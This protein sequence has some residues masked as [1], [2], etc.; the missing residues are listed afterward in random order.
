[1]GLNLAKLKETED[2]TVDLDKDSET[3][4][5]IDA[6]DESLEKTS[7]TTDDFAALAADITPSEPPV[8]DTEIEA[9]TSDS[10]EIDKPV[11]E[12][13]LAEDVVPISSETP[14]ADESLP[15]E[16][17]Q[18]IKQ[19]VS[20]G[21]GKLNLAQLS[22]IEDEVVSLPSDKNDVED[23]SEASLTAVSP[24]RKPP[25]DE[26]AAL[27]VD[28]TPSEPPTIDNDAVSA[29]TSTS[30][31]ETSPVESITDSTK[32]SDN[33]SD[34]LRALSN[35][36]SQRQT[37]GTSDNI[38]DFSDVLASMDPEAVQELEGRAKSLKRD[39]LARRNGVDPSEMREAM[40]EQ[41]QS[42]Q[43]GRQPQHG[44]G[45]AGLIDL[46]AGLV[47]AP[48][49]GAALGVSKFRRIISGS[50]NA[51]TAPDYSVD[52]L[53]DRIYE[54]KSQQMQSNAVAMLDATKTLGDHINAFNQEFQASDHMRA[55]LDEVNKTPGKSTADVLN[56][57]TNGTATPE[58]I[59]A[60][61]KVLSDPQVAAAWKNVE[62]QVDDLQKCQNLVKRDF[63][64]LNKN[65]PDRFDAETE[66]ETLENVVNQSFDSLP[67]PIVEDPE[68]NKKLAERLR[69]MAESLVERIK[70]LISKIM[71]MG[72]GAQ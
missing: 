1:M 63:E 2:E 62:A 11:S 46:A 8:V 41:D 3:P 42:R 35:G 20:N 6:S 36:G 47:S 26:F 19:T 49:V 54:L 15:S 18:D 55:F 38:G 32:V 5:V 17:V 53:R 25:V 21:K 68:K 34:V 50:K 69:E 66:A 67:K 70:E 52:A 33:L 29:T 45:A 28:I 27:V 31:A 13:V 61:R 48:F 7:D 39:S 37:L 64:L 44:G 22:K 60:A 30:A 65:F 12:T 57:V 9:S 72:R 40:H 43:Y 71:N 58:Q 59:E 51:G 24:S 16:S 23:A 4:T 14:K 56:D 10:T